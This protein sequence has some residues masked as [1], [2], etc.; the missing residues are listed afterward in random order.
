[1]K[2][3]SK[4]VVASFYTTTLVS[5]T[6]TTTPTYSFGSPLPPPTTQ[7]SILPVTPWPTAIPQNGLV[8]VSIQ[9]QSVLNGCRANL[10]GIQEILPF[11][12]I[13]GETKSTESTLATGFQVDTR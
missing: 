3:P 6:T 10:K 7:S 1:M 8:I 13:R 11:F 2:N 9:Y 4:Q 5:T 12:M